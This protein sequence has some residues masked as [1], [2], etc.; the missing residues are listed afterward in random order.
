MIELYPKPEQRIYFASD[1]HLGIDARDDTQKRE[2]KIVAWLD[3]C[4]KDAYAIFLVGDLFDFW[5][6]YK[7]TIPKGYTRF[8]GKLAELSDAGIELHIFTGNHDLWMFG[9]FEKELGAKVYH[10]PQELM[11]HEQLI[12]IGHGDGVGPGDKGYKMLK[13]IFTHPFY[14]WL[15]HWLHPNIGIGIANFWS[16]RSRAK[17]NNHEQ[18]FLGEEEWI[19]SYCKEMQKRKAHAYYLFGHRHLPLTLEVPPGGTYINLGEW[20]HSYSYAIYESGEIKLK[21]WN[22]S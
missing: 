4:K 2:Q 22:A 7:H 8:L 13:R 14:Q 15:F 18:I 9:Y 1:F 21:Y 16:G 5:F 11:I 19:W 12:L 6:E 3:A 17:A 20:L 10:E